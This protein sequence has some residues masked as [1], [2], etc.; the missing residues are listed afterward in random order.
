MITYFAYLL[1]SQDNLHVKYNNAFNCDDI[2]I[3]CDENDILHSIHFSKYWNVKYYF[4]I[5]NQKT[6]KYDK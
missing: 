1:L 5:H 2:I 6:E 3:I 4:H